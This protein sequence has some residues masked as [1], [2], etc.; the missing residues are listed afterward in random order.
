MAA[1][2]RKIVYLIRYPN[3]KV[4]V[5][6]DR[7]DTITYFGSPNPELVAAD[8]TEEQRQSF[9]VTREILWSS[10]TASDAEVTRVEVEMIRRFRS[11]DPTVGYNRWPRS[12]KPF[13]ALP[14]I[15]DA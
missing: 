10:T 9:T 5:G 14:N 4:Y 8:F 13:Q 7:T 11:N 2:R 6:Q 12:A 3:G 1:A 15:N